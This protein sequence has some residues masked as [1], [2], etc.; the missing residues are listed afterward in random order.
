MEY[1][2][3][4]GEVLLVNKPLTWSSFDAVN[5]VRYLVRDYLQVKKIKVG[6]AGTLDPLADG[7]LI[8]MTG[9]FTKR[10]EEFQ[11]FEKEYT[12]TLFL[13]KTTPSYD[14][15]HEPDE[16][17]P[18]EHITKE[19]ILETTKQFLGETDQVPPVY[20][21]VK[22]EGRRAYAYARKSQDLTLQARHILISEF[23]ITRIE[24][25]EVDFR[26]VCSK[27]T[28]IRSLARDFG[29]ALGSG[30][31]LQ[32]LR[33]TRIGEYRLENAWEI[34]DLDKHLRAKRFGDLE[35]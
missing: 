10:I 1:D 20:S 5:K 19:L 15:E 9:R 13:G 33:R 12:G 30:A 2:F 21:A 11:D 28:Y 24:M 25:P 16:E 7:L 35:I 14:L 17:Y 31:Y 23:E 32:S 6:H 27:G 29:E 4:T 3:V 34:P 8:I 22:H 26:V 18:T